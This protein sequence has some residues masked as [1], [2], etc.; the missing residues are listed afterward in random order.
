[1][2]KAVLIAIWLMLGLAT[3][4]FASNS[5]FSSNNS[6]SAFTDTSTPKIHSTSTQ[7]QVLVTLPSNYDASDIV[8]VEV[9]DHSYL[10]VYFHSHVS[11]RVDSVW[12]ARYT[13]DG[14]EK[15]NNAHKPVTKPLCEAG[16]AAFRKAQRSQ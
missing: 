13:N 9:N 14:L 3:S 5:A 2:M 7:N 12:C 8:K 1:M 6:S 11:G 16:I 10:A 15:T 4:S